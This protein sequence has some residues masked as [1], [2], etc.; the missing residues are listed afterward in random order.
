MSMPLP[1]LIAALRQ[2]EVFGQP[3][4][5]PV[6]VVQ[7]HISVVFLV[8][9]QVYKLKKPHDLG[10]LDF[11]TLALRQHFCA[12]EVELNRRLAPEVYRG[13]VELRRDATGNLRVTALD[14][15]SGDSFG[16][17]VDVMVQM[18]RLPDDA[19]LGHRIS[20]GLVDAAAM[21][22]LGARLWQ[23]HRDARRGADVSAWATFAAVAALARQN[24]V[25]LAGLPGI[26]EVLLGR[27]E[28]G[29][30]ELLRRHHDTIEARAHH[31]VPCDTHGDLRLDHV[32]MFPNEP[33]PRDLVIL[34]CIEFSDQFRCSDPIADVSFLVMDLHN[35]G[36]SDLAEALLD[37]YFAP[38]VAVADGGKTLATAVEGRALVP[39]YVAYRATVRG[40]VEALK[41][42]E[43][44]V[45]APAAAAAITRSQRHLLLALGHLVA[46]A[47]RPC[48]V[49]VA[50]LP[51]TGKSTLARGL[52]SEGMVWVRTDTVRKQLAGLAP[53][54][55]A[56]TAPDTG[57]YTPEW[58]QRTYE[59]CLELV[60]AAVVDGERVVV[61]GNFKLQRERAEF[62][63]L[64]Q[65]FGIPLVLCECEADVAVVEA[66]LRRRHGDA[67]DA[68]V[69][70]YH[71][72]RAVWEPFDPALAPVRIDTGV[73]PDAAIAALFGHLRHRG[74]A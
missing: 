40:K 73:S 13:V 56:R 28:H 46:P 23:F 16:E 33:P 61:D 62:I 15:D 67:S 42:N 12:R 50:G 14:D 7:T 34:D 55:S 51:G 48:L 1:T 26:S 3:A 6:E 60:R 38:A 49:L 64:A 17:L 47:L 31:D 5:T 29:T 63:A 19:T 8:G 74:L 9:D 57:I 18:H 66:R 52:A 11:S 25:Q 21:Q 54:T 2:P 22:Q 72:V 69:E 43:V 30:E 45:P 24:F 41:A 58:S 32:Y 65:E 20:A 27:V 59:R 37:G 44:E 4:G 53:E 36:R 35:H 39:F 71:R 70:I 68:D 10:F